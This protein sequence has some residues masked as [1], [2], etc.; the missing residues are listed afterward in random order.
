MPSPVTY[1]P[2]RR[3]NVVSVTVVACLLAAGWATYEWIRV[4]F[5]RQEAFRMLEE[6]SSTFS[7]RRALYRQSPN[8]VELLRQRMESSIQGIGVEDPDL[9]TWIELDGPNAT[10]GA[11]FSAWYHWPMDVLAPVEREFQIEHAIALPE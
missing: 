1:K 7:G 11:V 10:F 8:E 9:E 3:I 6:T 2:P 4:M 5:L